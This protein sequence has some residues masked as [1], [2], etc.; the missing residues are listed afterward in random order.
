MGNLNQS[1][2][3]TATGQVGVVNNEGGVT[4]NLSPSF[5][6][7]GFAGGF[8][9]P[10]RA[11]KAAEAMATMNK[12]IAESMAAYMSFSPT[13][14]PER[15]YLMAVT[16][17]VFTERQADNL[18]A[19]LNR[20]AGS[21]DGEADPDNLSDA[22]RDKII[23]GSREADEQE[24]REIWAKLILG[25][26]ESPGL[27]SKRSMDIL[28]NMARKDAEDFQA[29]CSICV[30]PLGGE[31]DPNSL[32][33]VENISSGLINGG[34]MSLLDRTNLESMGLVA[35]SIVSNRHVPAGGFVGLATKDGPVFIVNGGE[36]EKEV[37]FSPVLTNEGKELA[38]LCEDYIG[39]SKNLR[40]QISIKAEKSGLKV[41]DLS[42][43]ARVDVKITDVS[44]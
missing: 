32:L 39:S 13:V 34:V 20:V 8:L 36:R 4:V 42:D 16:G 44:H 25:E 7:S 5:K 2:S 27:Y 24:V 1:A 28:A 31:G 17:L 21:I 19:V 29:L 30:Y 37:A 10:R 6:L 11:K 35:T 14:S 40:E 9:A 38:R 12:A 22:T 18:L 41:G 15:A 26:L 3:S 23:E 33:V 43:F